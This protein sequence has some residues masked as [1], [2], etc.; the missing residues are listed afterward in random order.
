MRAAHECS[1][2]KS[3]AL[4]RMVRPFERDR[5]TAEGAGLPGADVADFAVVVVVP[6]LAGE[7]VGD[8]FAEF[9][10]SGGGEGVE[11]GKAAKAAGA[12]GIGHDGIEDAVVDGVVIAAEN[13]AGGAA[14]LRHRD[15]WRKKNK[16]ERVGRGGG[17]F[18][19]GDL[20]R[21]QILYRG[22]VDGFG[23]RGS[24]QG[25]GADE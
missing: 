14:A 19:G 7:G 18:A 21:D 4:V 8:G 10:G 9:V 17:E 22:V 12:A 1:V 3:D 2:W 24:G 20:W 23:G 5:V 13:F 11:I 16:V 6:A 15:A 25:D